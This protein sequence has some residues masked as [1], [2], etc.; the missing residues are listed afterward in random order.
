VFSPLRYSLVTIA[1]VLLAACATSAPPVTKLVGGRQISTRS[2]DPEAY[3]HVSRALL[4][5][6]QQAWQKAADELRRAIVLDGEAPEL[7]ARLGE[8]LLRMG[9]VK[10]AEAAVRASLRL[11]R[12]VPGLIALAHVRQANG[13]P[14]GV[15]E[16]LRQARAEVELR[17]EDDQ[18]EEVYLELA[19]AELQALDVRAA[20]ATLAALTQAE[21]G[22]ASGRMRLMAI[23]WA[24]G[25]M[26]KAEAELRAALAEEPNQIEAWVALAWIHTA[27]GRTNDA[28]ASFQEALD[29]SESALEIAAAYARFLV[30]SGDP[31]EA[32]QL[33]DDLAVPVGSL[34]PDALAGRIELERSARRLDRALALVGH[35]RDLGLSPEQKSR[36]ARIHAAL[37]KEQGK[38]SD[39]VAVLLK[40]SQDAPL[41][42][43]TR[44]VAAELLRESG[45]LVEAARSVEEAVPV[46][47]GARATIEVEAA[48]ALALIDE[49]RG[50]AA[51]AV[52]RLE[53]ALARQPGDA[54]LIMAMAAIEERRGKWQRALSLVEQHLKQHPSSVEALNFWGFVAADYH[55]ALELAGQRVQVAN[56]LEPGSGGLIDSL[57]W[58][59]FRR[60]DLTGATLFLEQAAR[61]EPSDAEIQW[62]LGQLYEARNDRER[63]L[64]AY[65]R[66]LGNKPD[67]R[68]RKKLEANVAQLLAQE[69]KAP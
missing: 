42:F 3:E 59:A 37:L 6:E 46:A 67:E 16:A 38:P 25:Q 5:E 12:S 35:G 33:A 22:S 8:L 31:R 9:D 56:A 43:E 64:A 23:H 63:A 68:V 2:I 39:G 65:R 45:K 17:A 52:A 58:V 36:L 14:A 47:A 66:G 26:G 32:E 41:Y 48:R 61:L 7:H 62:H 4:F 40:V 1:I 13:D 60:K 57:G 20:E 19:D 44:L 69:G 18:A 49:K 11:G 15:I 30:G 53:Q 24:K 28:R 50:D 34:T 29:R 54:K 55:H 10:G 27:M 21:P 51:A